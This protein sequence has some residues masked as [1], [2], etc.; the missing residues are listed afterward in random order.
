MPYHVCAYFM[1]WGY[2]S[3]YMPSRGPIALLEAGNNFVRTLFSH[4]LIV[5]A[6][7]CLQLPS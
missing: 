2:S 6:L 4:V 3:N 1:W 7:E 5:L